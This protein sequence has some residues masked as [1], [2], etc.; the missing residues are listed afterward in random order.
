MWSR[1]QKCGAGVGSSG[2]TPSIGQSWAHDMVRITVESAENLPKGGML[3]RASEAFCVVQWCGTT[4]RTSTRKASSSPVWGE[5]EFF[6]LRPESPFGTS[7]QDPVVL[8]DAGSTLELTVCDKRFRDKIRQ[9]VTGTPSQIADRGSLIGEAVLPGSEMCRIVRSLGESCSHEFVLRVQI[10]KKGVAVHNHNKEPCVLRLKVAVAPYNSISD[11]SR[12]CL[13]L[14]AAARQNISRTSFSLRSSAALFLRRCIRRQL[15]YATHLA[16]AVLLS[17]SLHRAQ[18]RGVRLGLR[19]HARWLNRA[20]AS[21]LT[22]WKEWSTES[23]ALHRTVQY[24]LTRWNSLCLSGALGSWCD[25]TLRRAERRKALEAEAR[26]SEERARATIS[27]L[28]LCMCARNRWQTVTFY[29]LVAM[30]EDAIRERGWVRL[31]AAAARGL[32]RGQYCRNF[33]DAHTLVRCVGSRSRDIFVSSI[34]TCASGVRTIYI[35]DLL[36]CTSHF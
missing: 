28:L 25:W 13:R 33:V 15:L 8:C 11:T 9:S 1:D 18:A 29:A 12:S 26:L 6:R 22:R 5:S 14:Q 36:L 35:W 32:V 19:C 7:L 2:Q 4:L 24:I 31:Q 34:A 16:A 27:S 3:G 20:V 23:N 17:A 30:E 10:S 21:S